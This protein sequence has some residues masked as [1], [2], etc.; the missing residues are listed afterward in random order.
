MTRLTGQEIKQRLIRLQNLERLYPVARKRIEK[1]EKENKELRTL[2]KQQGEVIQAQ[3][4]IIEKL[5][6]RIEDLEIKIFGK[7]KNRDRDQSGK[8]GAGNGKSENQSQ[9]RDPASYRKPIPKQEDISKTRE[10]Q[11]AHC[12]DCGTP[13]ID[14]KT[15]TQYKIELAFLDKILKEIER[16]NVQSGYCPECGKRVFAIPIQPAQVYFGQSLKQ[17][18]C[19]SII[20][21]RLSFGQTKDLIKTI[22]D[23]D[24]SEGEISSILQEHSESLK[25]EFERIEQQIQGEPAAHYDETVYNIFSE[26]AAGN[27][28]W[29]MAS[30]KTNDAIFAF[31]KNRGRGNASD[32]KGSGNPDQVGITDDYGA[33]KNLFG[34]NHQLCWAHLIRKFRDLAESDQLPQDKK[35]YCAGLHQSLKGI[36]H[37]LDQTLC[38]PFD[39]ESR[40]FANEVLR[41]KLEKLSKP[42]DLDCAK[43][44]TIKESLAKNLEF[45]FTCLLHQG[46]PATNNKAE[47]LLRHAVIKRKNSFGMQTQKGADAMSVL[48]SVLLSL[49]RRS[50]QNFFA[51]YRRLL[52]ESRALRA[53]PQ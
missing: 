22:A 46:V 6:L 19:H 2:V 24:I 18:V 52:D 33:Y 26:N 48:F 38:L 14:Q 25:P 16:Q 7:K 31:G 10:Y 17:F 40:R 50:K 8:D 21:L 23:I 5:K 9:S 53:S 11:I 45:Y 29:I 43:L 4:A 3:T 37:E 44:K 20:V 12:P 42:N 41:N 15:V 34:K 35:E 30:A 39:L 51:E 27:Y 32:L 28:A 47:Q 13:L 49:W 36:F 1:L